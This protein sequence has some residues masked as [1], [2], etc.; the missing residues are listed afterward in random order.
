MVPGDS[1]SL[2]RKGGSDRA[3]PQSP[4]PRALLLASTGNAGLGGRPFVKRLTSVRLGAMAKPS[5]VSALST[6]PPNP[7]WLE[8]YAGKQTNLK[9]R[10]LCTQ[11]SNSPPGSVF[12]DLE[13]ITVSLSQA[14]DFKK[15]K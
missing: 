4:T 5:A 10:P 9:V 14:L 8:W 13:K 15:I 7:G 6:A 12:Y 1:V 2:P 3:N 11:V